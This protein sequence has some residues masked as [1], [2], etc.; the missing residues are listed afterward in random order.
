MK[1]EVVEDQLDML[2]FHD[3]GHCLFA[4]SVIKLAS[5]D[6]CCV[7]ENERARTKEVVMAMDVG[8][9]SPLDLRSLRYPIPVRK[10]FTA[11]KSATG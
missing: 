2:A 8:V 3:F 5:L 6:A 7:I 10:S 9:G 4:G 1:D 11:L